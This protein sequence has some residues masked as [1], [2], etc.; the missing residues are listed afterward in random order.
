MNNSRFFLVGLAVLAI[1]GIGVIVF[2][3]DI[4]LWYNGVAAQQVFCTQDAK[5]C[6]DGSYVGRVAP[7]CAFAS[8]PSTTSP[9]ENQLETRINQGASALGV[10]VIPLSVLE[11]SRCAVEVTCI[12]AGTVRVRATLVGSMGESAQT[13]TLRIPIITESES[14]EL[15]EVLP[16]PHSGT[17][18]SGSYYLFIFKVMKHTAVIDAKG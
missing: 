9:Q 6:P 8:C 16:A 11:D 7:S 18:L 13:F 1:I 5:L 17:N 10:T 4:S 3:D 14:V 15:I 2:F 12:Q